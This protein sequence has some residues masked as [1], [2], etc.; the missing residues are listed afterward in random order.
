METTNTSRLWEM[1]VGTHLPRLWREVFGLESAGADRRRGKNKYCEEGRE[2]EGFDSTSYLQ[3]NG[4]Q[5]I[6]A[7]S[8]GKKD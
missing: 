4:S 8:S 3:E 5:H 6:A 1:N 7:Y 2:N